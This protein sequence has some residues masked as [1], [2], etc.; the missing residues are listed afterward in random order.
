MQYI[1]LLACWL[2]FHGLIILQPLMHNYANC[3]FNREVTLISLCT[4]SA[5][6]DQKFNRSHAHLQARPYDR[7]YT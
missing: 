2:A 4:F 6:G 5:S 1:S 3:L 7:T